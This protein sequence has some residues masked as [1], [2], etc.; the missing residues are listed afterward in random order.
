M[1]S[2]PGTSEASPRRKKR[3]GERRRHVPQR[4]CVGC[5]TVRPKRELMR[6]VL[7]PE[8]KVEVDADGKRPGR[9][10]YLCRQKRCWEMAIERHS[11]DRALKT[12]LDDETRTMLAACAEKL[13][14]F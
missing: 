12:R 13:E 6:L 10:A 2:G 7:T 8:G 1:K 4:T 14:S 5:R 11:L 9:G 3:T